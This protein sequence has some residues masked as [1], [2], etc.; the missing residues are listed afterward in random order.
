MFKCTHC[1]GDVV[2]SDGSRFKI[3][4]II[5]RGYIFCSK[6]CQICSQKKNGFLYKRNV[7]NCRKKHG[8][9]HITQLQTTKDK[10]KKTTFEHY[11]VECNLQADVIKAQIKKTCT[12]LYGVDCALKLRAC[13]EK[14]NQAS[15]SQEVQEKIKQTN[16]QRYGAETPF[17]AKS[18]REKAKQTCKLHHGA[19]YP[20]QCTHIKAKQEKTCERIYGFK[21]AAKAER[22]KKKIKDT[23]ITRY[24]STCSFQAP[25]LAEKCHSK[26]TSTKR[27]QTMKKNGTYRKSNPEN[28]C[29]VLLCKSYGQENIERQTRINDWNIDFYIKSINVYIQLDGVYWHGL[30]RPIEIIKESKHPRDKVIYRTW[31]RDQEQSVW[32]KENNLKLIRITDVQLKTMS[33][34]S[35]QECLQSL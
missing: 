16:V 28:D 14:T 27:H 4:T 35:L 21:N 34:V 2:V 26:E 1:G 3:A 20:L 15:K 7:E 23:N 32:F 33:I 29:Y 6:K 24:G 30:N 9:N 5:N 19:E 22:T 17:K 25:H 11:G 8:V 13:R 12:K 31:L 18:C 10:I